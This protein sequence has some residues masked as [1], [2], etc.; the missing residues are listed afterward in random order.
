MTNLNK[1]KA[2]IIVNS[3][4]QDNDQVLEGKT[5]VSF[6]YIKFVMSLIYQSKGIQMSDK[7]VWMV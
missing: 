3:N 1:Q 4:Q 5:V 7:Q 2:N 6:G